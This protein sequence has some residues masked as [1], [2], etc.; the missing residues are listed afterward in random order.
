MSEI[1]KKKI[2]ASAVRVE[3]KKGEASEE[4]CPTC[5]R[6]RKKLDHATQSLKNLV[7]KYQTL[8][9]E[10]DAANYE[11]ALWAVGLALDEFRPPE[12]V[13]SRIE[14]D[15][16]QIRQEIVEADFQMESMKS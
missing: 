3:D 5:K 13:S 4:E 16:S 12:P 11:I 7:G 6:L 1:Q 15:A 14:F 8:C 10:L 2:S 9:E